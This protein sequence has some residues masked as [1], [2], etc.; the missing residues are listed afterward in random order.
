ML[1][2]KSWLSPLFHLRSS[3]NV[4][5]QCLWVILAL[6]ACLAVTTCVADCNF[7]APSLNLSP[8]P[9]PVNLVTQ[10]PPTP[11]IKKLQIHC[12]RITSSSWWS[13]LL[14]AQP[15]PVQR[16]PACYL[17]RISKCILTSH[18]NGAPTSIFKDCVCGGIPPLQ[19]LVFHLPE[20]AALQSGG[21]S[22]FLED[23]LQGKNTVLPLRV[24]PPSLD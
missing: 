22:A 12:L 11:R 3:F 15:S 9:P 10:L 16:T 14:P 8:P 18:S 23:H 19:R 6:K 20:V 17:P 7:Q 24:L 1:H 21:D 4:C 5:T 2:P 13:S